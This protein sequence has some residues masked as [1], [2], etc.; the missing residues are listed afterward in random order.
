[1]LDGWGELTCREAN[2]LLSERLDHAL[3]PADQARLWFH[4]RAC[5]LCRRV[6]DQMSFLREAMRRLAR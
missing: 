3:S 2:R 1:M 6:A 5:D 4:L